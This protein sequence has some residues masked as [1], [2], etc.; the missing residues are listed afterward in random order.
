MSESSRKKIYELFGKIKSDKKTILIIITGFLGILLIFISEIPTQKDEFT[1]NHSNEPYYIN[2]EKNELE[3]I[4]SKINGV[5]RVSVMITY[6]G[7][8]ENVY[9]QNL[10]EQ[11]DE[12]KTKKEEEL[13]I[14]DKGNT[15][16]GLLLKEIYPEIT[17]IAVV[18]EGGGDPTTK[19]EITQMLKALYNIG[20]NN[21][22]ISEMNS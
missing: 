18:C 14:L 10:S 3:K 6:K 20:S 21:I 5:G 1:E 11:N 4:I 16:D 12:A 17:G 22:S 2:E 9:A 15:E 8:A 13:I 19:T 7:T